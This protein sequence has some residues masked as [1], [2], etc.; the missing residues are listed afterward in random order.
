MSS[1]KLDRLRANSASDMVTS[2]QTNAPVTWLRR[3]LSPKPN[4]T[5]FT[6]MSYQFDQNVERIPP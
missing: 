6:C 2:P 1:P 4:C 3:P 5:V